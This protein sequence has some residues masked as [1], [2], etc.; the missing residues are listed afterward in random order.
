MSYMLVTAEMYNLSKKVNELIKLGWKPLG[1]PSKA[2]G[3]MSKD[4][5]V[6]AMVKDI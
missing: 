3:T 1:G 5:L 4:V 6:Q 2:Y